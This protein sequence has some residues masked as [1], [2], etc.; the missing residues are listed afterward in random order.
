[1]ELLPNKA[2]HITV[3]GSV[4]ETSPLNGKTF[5]LEEVQKMV[6]GLIE[7][8]YLS[9]EQIMIVNETGKFDKEYNPFATAIAQLYG[10]ITSRDYICG[11]VV[12]CP[13]PMLP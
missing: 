9:D 3:E 5:E 13:S 12:I 8:V 2:Y 6:E 7:I 11:N 4:T 10:A 1:M